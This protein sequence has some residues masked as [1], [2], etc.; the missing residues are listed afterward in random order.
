MGLLSVVICHAAA[1][2]AFYQAFVAG[3]ERAN[4]V[5]IH[6]AYG[7]SG[8]YSHPWEEAELRAAPVLIVLLSRA[9]L[10]SPRVRSETRRFVE[11]Q[12]DDLSRLVLPVVIEPIEPEAIW[13]FLQP[14]RRVEGLAG[15]RLS[16]EALVRGALRALGIY[17]APYETLVPDAVEEEWQ[18]DDLPIAVA[19]H[20]G[21][22]DIQY[23]SGASPHDARSAQG[24]A[25]PESARRRWLVLAG[26]LLLLVML[27]IVVGSGLLRHA[28][29]GRP[30]VTPTSQATATVQGK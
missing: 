28:A 19:P 2:D 22:D 6:A 14:Y 9:A 3:L 11:L 30:A 4:V 26:V 16:A 1:D 24:E 17:I 29:S 10:A 15:A 20:A 23:A 27:L 7:A 13:P 5:V 21:E 25:A 8:P 12:A 18:P